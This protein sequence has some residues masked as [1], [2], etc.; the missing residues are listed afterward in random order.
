VD[1]YLTGTK[2]PWRLGYRPA[3]DG[4]RGFAVLI[5]LGSHFDV[6][7]LWNGGGVG[8][9][10]FFALSGFLITSLLLEERER[11][12][13]INL[14]AFYGRRAR[15]LL[16]ALYVVVTF[17]L[18]ASWALGV[19]DDAWP[20]ILSA[21]LYYTN[22]ALAYGVETGTMHHTWSLAV[23]EQFY[24]V[25]PLAVIGAGAAWY[26]ARWAGMALGLVAMMIL[27][28]PGIALLA[29]CLLSVGLHRGL[30]L[31]VPAWAGGLGFAAIMFLTIAPFG[32]TLGMG[33]TGIVGAVILASL[34]GSESW[35]TR[36]LSW[37]PLRGSGRISYALYLWHPVL[38]GT[39]F[40]LG[41]DKGPVVNIALVGLT[42]LM[43]LASW[44]WV[45]S[46]FLRRRQV[47]ESDVGVT[48]RAFQ[49]GVVQQPFAADDD[50]RRP[51]TALE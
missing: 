31:W 2:V 27:G 30:R 28:Q 20:G 50:R 40:L 34:S 38:L 9:G 22:W 24:A 23:E 25:W 7:L 18:A 29:G 12:G 41:F 47:G 5:V 3:L 42:F 32:W 16:P 43:A 48:R 13:K 21:G 6:P 4:L 8:V 51:H 33:V 46:P 36:A 45:E 49:P 44:R 15:R 10:I 26:V 14:L 35:L 19:F 37:R 17:W 1:K 11:T 39:A